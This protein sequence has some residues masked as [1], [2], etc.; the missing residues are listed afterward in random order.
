MFSILIAKMALFAGNLLHRGSALPGSIALKLNKNIL[1]KFKLPKNIIAVTGSA[2][3]GTTSKLIAETLK[4]Q[5]FKVVHNHRGGNLKSGIVTMLVE[6]SDLFGNIKADYLVY[7]IDERYFKQVYTKLE[8]T[9][10]VI[11]NLVRDQQPRQGNIDFVYN[12]IK[13]CLTSKTH[14]ILN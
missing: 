11:T 3:K 1:E 4:S 8:P 2:G 9:T 7:E 5:G 10:V 6:A 12:D 14:L 13:M